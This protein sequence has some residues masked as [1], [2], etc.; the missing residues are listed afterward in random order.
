MRICNLFIFFIIGMA[1]NINQLME[2]DVETIHIQVDLN[3]VVAP[4]EPVWSWVGYDEPNYTYMK[5]GQ[6]LLTELAEA[7][8][9]PVYV[10]AHNWLTS[11]D[12]TPALKWGS[13]NAY[14]EDE[15]GNPVYDWTI[16]DQIFDCYVERGMKPLVEIGFMPEALSSKPQPYQHSWSILRSRPVEAGCYSVKRFD[17]ICDGYNSSNSEAALGLAALV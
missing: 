15:N 10:R 4:I 9:G 2:Q 12:G 5:D 13:T 3:D 14:T 8:S 17:L 16:I 11:G 7:N 6:K 1:F